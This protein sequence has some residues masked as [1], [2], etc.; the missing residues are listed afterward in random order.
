MG[1][2]ILWLLGVDESKGVIGLNNE[3]EVSNWYSSVEKYFQDVMPRLAKSINIKYGELTFFA[4]LFETDRAPYVVKTPEGGR[5][6]CEVP[7]RIGNSTQTARRADL[8][9]ILTP[10]TK[11]P[12]IEILGTNSNLKFAGMEDIYWVSFDLYIVP[13]EGQEL[14]IPY[15]KCEANFSFSNGLE[16]NHDSLDFRSRSRNDEDSLYLTISANE[17]VFFGPAR[18]EMRV[19]FRKPATDT[20]VE[21][22]IDVQVKL[23]PSREIPPII[24]HQD[25]EVRTD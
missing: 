14:V 18:I 23:R 17:I 22:Q 2:S 24:F 20:W 7:W 1:E 3:V 9:R 19:S 11:L 13:K 12:D 10:S 5:I 4:L 25:F 6:Q 21:E 8:L 16:Y 15:H